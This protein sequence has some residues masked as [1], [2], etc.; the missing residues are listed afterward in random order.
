MKKQHRL[1]VYGTLKQGQYFHNDY[2]SG[3]KSEFVGLATASPDFSLYIDGLPHLIREPTDMP[4]K[5][6]LFQIDEDVLNRIDEL[7]G[8]P[9]V[10]KREIIEVFDESG[11]RVLAWAY[12]RHHNFKGKAH[13]YKDNEF[14]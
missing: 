6:E 2:L 4:V 10:Y 13:S 14:T 3:D 8:H 11:E 12:L 1:F 5:G 9:V 7:E